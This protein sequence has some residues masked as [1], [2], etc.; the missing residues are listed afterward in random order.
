MLV[1]AKKVDY[2]RCPPEVA[3]FAPP[4]QVRLTV[5][6]MYEVHAVA[7]FNGI[8]MLQVIDDLRYPTWEPM[9][10]FDLQ[11]RTLPDDWI[12]NLFHDEPSMVLGPEFVA[13]DEESY[14]AMVELEAE[15]VDLF[16]KRVESRRP[17]TEDEP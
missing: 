4:E 10:L 7:V 9:W 15:Q 6:K 8:I 3:R 14:G 11:D 17:S 16:W 13:R 5:G 1:V 12:C 2:A